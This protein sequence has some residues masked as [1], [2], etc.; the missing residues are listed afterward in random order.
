MA[1]EDYERG[2]ATDSGSLASPRPS[3]TS[4]SAAQEPPPNDTV[5]EKNAVDES[6]PPDGGY[7]WVCTACVAAVNGHT[8]GINSVSLSFALDRYNASRS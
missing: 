3:N 6:Q 7:G 8:W 5:A 1:E 2:A 4:G